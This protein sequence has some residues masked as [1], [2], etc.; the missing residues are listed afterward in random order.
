[1]VRTIPVEEANLE[2]QRPG[3]GELNSDDRLKY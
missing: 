1:L 3:D 2:Q